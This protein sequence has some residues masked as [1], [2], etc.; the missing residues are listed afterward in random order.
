MINKCVLAYQPY[1]LSPS[2]FYGE[3]Q[4]FSSDILPSKE[5]PALVIGYEAV[6]HLH[7]LVVNRP[8]PALNKVR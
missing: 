2:S 7:T 5:I 3:M 8:R 4:E 6:S 1:R